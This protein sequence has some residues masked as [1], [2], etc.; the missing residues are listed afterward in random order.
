MNNLNF[1]KKKLKDWSLIVVSNREPYLHSYNKV[2]KKDGKREV[3]C[4]IPAGGLTAV[5]DPVMR[6]F[7]GLWVAGSQ[8]EADLEFV[9]ENNK[10]LVP[11]K[12]PKYTLKRVWLPQEDYDKF[13]FGFANSTL[14]PLCHL[15]FQRPEFNLEYWKSYQK[16]NKAYAQ[17]CLEDIQTLEK[18]PLIFIQDYQLALVPGIIREKMP[19]AKLIHFWHIPWPSPANFNICP[20]EWRKALLQGLLANDLLGFHITKYVKRFLDTVKAEFGDNVEVDFENSLVKQKDHITYVRSFPIGIDARGIEKKAKSSKVKEEMKKI[21]QAYPYGPI[22]I[23]IDRLDYTK[24][25]PERFEAI[26]VFLKNNPRYQ[27]AFNFIELAAPSREKVPAYQKIEEKINRLVKEIND[28][29]GQNSTWRPIVFI[30]EKVSIERLLAT[31]R[32]ADLCIVSSLEDGM[33]I[34]AK[35]FPASQ[36]DNS[37]VLLLSEFAGAAEELREAVLINPFDIEDFAGKIKFALEMSEKE[38]KERMEKL[39]KRVKDN[40]SSYWV[41]NILSQAIELKIIC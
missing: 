14:W 2:I 15:V 9:D 16:V 6:V 41:A 38:K 11:P 35:E 19:M 24:G 12:D 25:I 7:G 1:F 23:G 33:N 10:I 13:Y 20:A 27:K 22:I 34:V 8:G 4:K 21:K 28:E 17:A 29:Y 18:K 30:K 40:D 31:Y 36:I 39:R 26:K 5:L 32:A 3:V 37:G